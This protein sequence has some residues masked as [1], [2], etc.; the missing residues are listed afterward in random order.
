M[1]PGDSVGLLPL[2]GH[3]GGKLGVPQM[4]GYTHSWWRV[5]LVWIQGAVPC[6]ACHPMRPPASATCRSA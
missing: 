5:V 1:Q 6:R 4:Y 3:A 2:L